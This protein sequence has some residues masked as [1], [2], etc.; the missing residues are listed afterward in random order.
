LENRKAAIGQSSAEFAE[1]E[2]R[3][4][5]QGLTAG[6]DV[7]QKRASIGGPSSASTVE[8]GA[9]TEAK[10]LD[11]SVRDRQ[12][13]IASRPA[14][15]RSSQVIIEEG[16]TDCDHFVPQ[17]F[18]KHRYAFGPTP[19][20]SSP[21]CPAFFFLLISSFYPFFPHFNSSPTKV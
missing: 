20:S 5:I 16:T 12:R 11:V 3:K 15:R 18:R 1:A 9:R 4:E 19:L 2:H 7:S 10:N 17:L 6:V 13:D 8:S 14:G 21:A